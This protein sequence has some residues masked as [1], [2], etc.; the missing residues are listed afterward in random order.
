[1]KA[2]ILIADGFEDIE[3]FHLWYRLQ[4]EGVPTT[5]ISIHSHTLTGLRGYKV[6][7]D[8]L[9]RDIA[10]TDYDLLLIPGGSSPERLRTREEAVG[11]TRSFMQEG[12]LVGAISHGVQV[13]ISAG[14]M[15]N[16]AVTCSP[17]IRD[18]ARSAGG[19]YRDDA[20][21]VDD[22]LIT[23]RSRED[24]PE[25]TAKIVALIGEKVR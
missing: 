14:S 19:R 23:G 20:V 11:L 6:E 18:D 5:I 4:E 13:I 25:F 17:S 22:N 10:H 1:M 12:Q 16:R 7:P 24:L 2:L 15:D 21:V 8:L 9:I 3:F